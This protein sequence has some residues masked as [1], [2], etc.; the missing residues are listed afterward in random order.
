MQHDCGNTES[1]ATSKSDVAQLKKPPHTVSGSTLLFQ[2]HKNNA[3]NNPILVLADERT[4]NF[5]ADDMLLYKPM[6]LNKDF[7]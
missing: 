4:F 7:N 5:Y 6:D 3:A 1:K 2:V